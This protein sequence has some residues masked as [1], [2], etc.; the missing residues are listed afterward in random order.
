M[1]RSKLSLRIDRLFRWCWVLMLVNLV[2]SIAFLYIYPYSSGMET[3]SPLGWCVMAC[4]YM[5]TIPFLIVFL[6]LMAGFW[7]LLPG[8]RVSPT[9][10]ALF[11]LIPGFS[12]Y[13]PFHC[14]LS[15]G[16]GFDRM[17]P[18]EFPKAGPWP[19]IYCIMGV[20]GI[21]VGLALTVTGM[22]FPQ[23]DGIGLRT[24]SAL[25]SGLNCLL[26]IWTMN[27]F[28]LAAQWILSSAPASEA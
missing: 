22:M 16:W 26:I 20:V 18:P 21:V 6:M 13:W 7:R 3:M 2:P 5:I 27:R 24:G 25:L 19:L 11:W 10:A 15:I 8:K 14:F 1:E 4:V 23:Y 9:A 12:L 17:T 28:R